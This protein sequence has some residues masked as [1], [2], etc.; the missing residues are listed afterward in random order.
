MKIIVP[1]DSDKKT[2]FK[3]TGRAPFFAI[4]EDD[5]LIEI[6]ENLHALSHE[7]EDDNK[8]HHEKHSS[9]EVAHHREDI[10]ELE[11]CD[12]ILTQA[13]G[14]NMQEALESI[15]IKIQKISRVDGDDVY[16]VLNRFL[17]GK[18]KRQTPQTITFATS[19]SKRLIFPTNENAGTLS[20]R[21]AHF[22]KANYY[23]IVTVYNTTI[24]DVEVI[25]NPGHKSGGCSDAVANIMSLKP[26][27][28][29]VGGI[30]GSPAKGFAQAGL[31]VYFDQ[32]SLTVQESV[33]MFLQNKLTKIND[34]GT[35]SIH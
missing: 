8:H 7:N 34:T 22:G 23:T 6:K 28:L 5:N 32:H 24:V 16:E 21:G 26:D 29:I 4:F 31:D 17:V 1:V 27:V 33:D 35:C 10:L 9:D 2:V 11:G 18:L 30:G 12:V 14:P 25:D 20:K 3:R 13:V 19:K 15:G